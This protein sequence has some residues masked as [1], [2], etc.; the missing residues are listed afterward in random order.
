MYPMGYS[1]CRLD[2]PSSIEIGSTQSRMWSRV[3]ASEPGSIGSCTGLL[4]DIDACRAVSVSSNWISGRGIACITQSERASWS[5]FA[6]AIRPA[7]GGIFTRLLCWR[8]SYENHQKTEI[9]SR[10][11]EDF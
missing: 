8:D 10:Q 11:N 7:N 2:L 4:V 5:C 3:P 9:H 1:R 6:V